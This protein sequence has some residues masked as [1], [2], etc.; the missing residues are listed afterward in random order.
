MTKVNSITWKW[1]LVAYMLSVLAVSFSAR[2]N[3]LTWITNEVPVGLQKNMRVFSGEVAL[4]ID[5][6]AYLVTTKNEV[7][8]LVSENLDL[9]ELNGV[10]VQ[11]KG[12]EPR[13]NVGPVYRTQAILP[14]VDES[15]TRSPRASVLVVVS[16]RVIE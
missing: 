4:D 1:V 14:L 6:N 3:E 13:Y 8:Q 16:I 10:F 12:F 2:A 11:V 7:F 5:G 15:E 9:S